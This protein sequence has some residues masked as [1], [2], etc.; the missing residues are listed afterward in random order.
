MCAIVVDIAV[1]QY[2]ATHRLPWQCGCC[3]E[4]QQPPLLAVKLE[5]EQL[6]ISMLDDPSVS[7]VIKWDPLVSTP[8]GQP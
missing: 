8:K 1:Q 2:L 5:L 3:P 4:Q 6:I 7:C